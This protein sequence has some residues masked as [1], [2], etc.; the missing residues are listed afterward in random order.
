[1]S[2]LVKRLR[3]A[4]DGTPGG[5]ALEEEAADEIERLRALCGKAKNEMLASQLT[6]TPP[7]DNALLAELRKASE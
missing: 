7:M 1:M 6:N 2:D 4:W 3:R 5:G